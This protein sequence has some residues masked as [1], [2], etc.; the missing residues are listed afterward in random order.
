M[1]PVAPFL[2]FGLIFCFKRHAQRFEGDSF[3]KKA[4]CFES[5]SLKIF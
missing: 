4:Q 3:K 1:N 2:N 5:A